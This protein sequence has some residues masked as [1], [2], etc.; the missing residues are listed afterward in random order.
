MQITVFSIYKQGYVKTL[1]IWTALNDEDSDTN[2][3]LYSSLKLNVST[4][5]NIEWYEICLV[6]LMQVIE[7]AALLVQVIKQHLNGSTDSYTGYRTCRT[8]WQLLFKK[9]YD[10]ACYTRLNRSINSEFSMQISLI[11]P[12][13]SSIVS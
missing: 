13:K 11:L 1:N 4:V 12:S 2:P 8:Q 3:V 7:P 5:Y 10:P 9:Y 6:Q